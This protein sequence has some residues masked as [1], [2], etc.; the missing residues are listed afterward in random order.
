ML[1]KSDVEMSGSTRPEMELLRKPITA[2]EVKFIGIVGVSIA[3]IAA[4]F[5]FD[6]AQKST[7]EAMLKP[8]MLRLAE[9]GKPS[10]MIWASS[11]KFLTYPNAAARTKALAE[12]GHLDSMYLYG[13]SLEAAGDLE[14]AYIWYQKAADEGHSNALLKILKKTG[15]PQ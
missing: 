11:R 12:A 5:A 4:I 6:S 3:L 1:P 7:D 10:A 2:L 15:S 13:Q 9:E 14:L 8:A